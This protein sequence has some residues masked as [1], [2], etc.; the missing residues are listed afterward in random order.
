MME[1]AEKF[2]LE[3][4]PSPGARVRAESPKKVGG[5]GDL[6]RRPG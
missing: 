1:I 3:I 6:E 5:A 2:A 4:L